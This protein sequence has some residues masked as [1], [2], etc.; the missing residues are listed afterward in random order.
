MLKLPKLSGQEIVKIL[1]KEFGFEISRQ[2]G[3]HVV[4]R[5]ME[6]G[7]KIVTIVPLHEEVKPGTLMGILRLARIR[8]E[9]FLEKLK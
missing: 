6:K 2:R 8:K 3:S 9:E 7:K 5:K 4:L 1:I